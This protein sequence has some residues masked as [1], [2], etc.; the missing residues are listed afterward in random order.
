MLLEKNLSPRFDPLVKHVKN[1]HDLRMASASALMVIHNDK[2]VAETYHSFLSTLPGSKP[3]QPQSQFNVASV[4]KSLIGFSVAWAMYNG[5]LGS[6]DDPVL[7]YLPNL[8]KDVMKGITLR[9]LLTHTHGLRTNEKDEL[10]NHFT[11]GSGWDYRGENIRLLT[12][13]V[14]QVTGKTVAQICREHVF[15]PMGLTEIGWRT[16]PHDDLVQ[17]VHDPGRGASSELKMSPDG[18]MPNLFAS[19]RNLACWGYLHL[20]RGCINGKQIVPEQ[21]I[22]WITAL[23]SPKLPSSDLPQNGFL[24][25]VKDRPAKQSEIG[26]QVPPGS[27]QILGAMEQAVLVIPTHNIVVVRLMNRLGN[28]P[29]Y[30]YLESIRSF[31]DC[32]MQCLHTD[33]DSKL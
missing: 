6:I 5:R 29:G 16:K 18:D 8:N 12:E 13:I 7:Q 23:Q 21:I 9:H 22:D 17:V 30:N 4:R 33:A 24:W 2:I 31:G 3:V 20:K 26:S 32:V 11:A 14:H 1:L 10:Y 25:Q 15:L 27:Y 28:P 19:T